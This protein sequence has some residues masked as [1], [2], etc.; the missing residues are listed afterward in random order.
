MSTDTRARTEIPRAAWVIAVTLAVL[1][2]VAM[3]Y[4]PFQFER[5]LQEWPLELK[6]LMIVLPALFTGGYALLV[7]F[8]YNDAKR[9]SMR[10]VMWAWLAMVPY[11]LGV[12]TY[13][14]LRDPLPTPCP[15][16]R[17]EVPRSYIF[18]PACGAAVHPSCKGCARQLEESWSNCPHCGARVVKSAEALAAAAPVEQSPLAR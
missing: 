6:V 11:F 8:I 3:W 15:K 2:A 7:G 5:E 4:G 9:R 10:H 14:I 16:C 18:C 12:I 1:L 13:F 17:Y